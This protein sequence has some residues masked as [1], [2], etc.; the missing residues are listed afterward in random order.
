MFCSVQ[1]TLNTSFRLHCHISPV[2]TDVYVTSLIRELPINRAKMDI[3]RPFMYIN[4][5]KMD[6]NGV[7]MD[8]SRSFMGINRQ[9]LGEKASQI[10]VAGFRK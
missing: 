8:I 4:R 7:F 5:V 6:I 1:S 2:N 3:N 9:K 10:S